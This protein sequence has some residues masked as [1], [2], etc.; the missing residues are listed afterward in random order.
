MT[1]DGLPSELAPA[2]SA[3]K[4]HA[5]IQRFQEKRVLVIGDMVADEYLM[6]TPVEIAREAPVLKLEV[7]E[8]RIIPG[9]AANP[10]VNARTLG[11][12]VCVAG[13]VGDDVAG[14]KLRTAI[15]AYGIQESLM[16]TDPTRPTTL[17]TRVMAGSAQVVQQMVLRIDRVN[18][19]ELNE[20]LQNL[21]I[22]SL[23][24]VIPNVDVVMFS[25]YENG[26][27]SPAVIE[28][29]LPLARESGK[30]IVADS[31][32]S[33]FR[34]QGASA[35]TPN[36]PEAEA[37]TGITIKTLADLHEAG[38]RL[39]R[40]CNAQSVLITRGAEGM[41]LFEAGKQPLH[42]P[43]FPLRNASK[44]VD[45]NGAGD[46][47]A[48]TYA[49][50]LAAGASM[51]EAAYLANAAASLVVRILGCASNTPEELMSLFV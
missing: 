47:V 24:A 14:Q 51:P 12:R 2:I 36:Q 18:R 38:E 16:L 26:M 17:K 11:A 29:C 5:I 46:T 28:S 10:A 32:G 8:E 40:G 19:N 31:H 39:L 23:K 49:L 25:D 22:A 43:I 7:F 1:L 45:T 13:V 3:E 20:Q 44:I 27:I 4:L 50:A 35:I 15:K 33:F 37:A 21:L 34:F 41:S 48:A 30:V 42:L 9:G 6:G